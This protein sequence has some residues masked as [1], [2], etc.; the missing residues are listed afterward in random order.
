MPLLS[1]VLSAKIV[2]VVGPHQCDVH[3]KEKGSEHRALRNAG[4]N[5]VQGG[6][7]SVHPHSLLPC[8]R[9]KEGRQPA[10]H[11][12]HDARVP[13]PVKQ[14]AIL[15]LV[16]GFFVICIDQLHNKDGALK[17]L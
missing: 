17:Q 12:A 15:A 13:E 6:Q 2:M 7:P 11:P 1:L 14:D 5:R 4:G 9:V 3:Q 10:A 8:G 16:K